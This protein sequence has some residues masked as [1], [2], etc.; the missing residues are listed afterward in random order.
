[1]HSGGERKPKK[2]PRDWV[3]VLG[4]QNISELRVEGSVF[5]R[6]TDHLGEKEALK[7]VAERDPCAE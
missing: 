4:R 2:E 3:C 6:Q 7:I 1:V 5:H